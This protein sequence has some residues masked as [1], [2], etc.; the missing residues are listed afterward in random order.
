MSASRLL[1]VPI[2]LR[3]SDMDALGHVN[4]SVY[5]TYVEEARLRWLQTVPGGWITDAISPVLVAQ[6]VNFRMPITWPQDIEVELYA[7]RIGGSSLTLEF[8]VL[9]AGDANTLFADGHSVMVWTG[10]DGKSVP[11]PE[12]IRAACLIGADTST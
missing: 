9:A 6:H 2:T 7:G 4:N 5:A 10:R 8:R 12:H 11:L 3:W 1:T